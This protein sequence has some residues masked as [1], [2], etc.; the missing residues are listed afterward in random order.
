LQSGRPSLGLYFAAAALANIPFWILTGLLSLLQPEGPIN[1][2]LLFT[3]VLLG[4]MAGGRFLTSR[5]EGAWWRT[6]VEAALAAFLVNI[7]FGVGTFSIDYLYV[8][9]LILVGFFLG[10]PI[11]ARIGMKHQSNLPAHVQQPA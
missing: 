5:L 8:L 7:F 11:G 4:G 2:I 6:G 9:T 1:V 10:G 3:S